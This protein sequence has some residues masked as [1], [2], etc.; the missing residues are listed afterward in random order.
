MS[1]AAYRITT[2]AEAQATTVMLTA[3]TVRQ[4]DLVW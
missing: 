3:R 2:K 4:S 1:C